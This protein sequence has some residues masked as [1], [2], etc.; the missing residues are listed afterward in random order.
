M[1]NL[2]ICI[3]IMLSGIF[4]YSCKNSQ[5]PQQKYAHLEKIPVNEKVVMPEKSAKDITEINKL[6]KNEENIFTHN[7]ESDNNIDNT[8]PQN[9]NA[10]LIAS[11]TY[12]SKKNSNNLSIKKAIAETKTLLNNT[13]LTN[14]APAKLTL[15]GK[16]QQ[17]KQLQQLK[18]ALKTSSNLSSTDILLI[19]LLGLI[20]IVFLILFGD[21]II[22][23]LLIILLVLL[24][25]L[26][27]KLV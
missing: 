26:L 21:L 9:E 20:G 12:N 8:N 27:A 1:K 6:V 19:V 13:N 5:F 17:F 16:V 3:I 15:K 11:T 22:L 23:L 4:F 18:K 2:K 10:S 7:A 14:N 24:I 25:L